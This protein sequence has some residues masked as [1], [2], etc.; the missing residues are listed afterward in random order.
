MIDLKQT[1][2]TVMQTYRTLQ[3]YGVQLGSCVT[4]CGGFVICGS[5]DGVVHVWNTDTGDEVYRYEEEAVFGAEVGVTGGPVVARAIAFH[6]LDHIL[7]MAAKN[8]LVAFKHRS[9]KEEK[10]EE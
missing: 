2:T 3:G 10:A 8:R 1:N 4:P 9:A 7:S 5:Q 6:P